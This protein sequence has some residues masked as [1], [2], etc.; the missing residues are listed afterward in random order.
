[1]DGFRIWTLPEPGAGAFTNSDILLV[2]VGYVYYEAVVSISLEN[3]YGDNGISAGA[4]IKLNVYLKLKQ[5][6]QEDE[7]IFRL[8]SF[9]MPLISEVNNE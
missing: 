3:Q 8:I 9:I 4:R 1:M 6:R 7:D 2:L 5:A